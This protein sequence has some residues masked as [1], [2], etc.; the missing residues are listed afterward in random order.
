MVNSHKRKCTMIHAITV[1]TMADSNRPNVRVLSSER[2]FGLPLLLCYKYV[3]I[4]DIAKA[5]NI[6]FSESASILLKF[7]AIHFL[8]LALIS[9]TCSK[10][11][12][13]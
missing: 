1:L 3:S 12:N 11:I 6:D 4:V 5:F 9:L 2:G 13:I 10:S 8:T 7:I